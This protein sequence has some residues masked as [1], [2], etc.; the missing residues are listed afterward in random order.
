[1]GSRLNCIYCMVI[2]LGL[3][4]NLF[5]LLWISI[6]VLKFKIMFNINILLDMLLKVIY[7][8]FMLLVKNV[9]VIGRI[10]ILMISRES[11]IRF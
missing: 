6:L 1:M 7:E 11:I 9:M 2:F 3:S 4:I 5:G 8:G 10:N